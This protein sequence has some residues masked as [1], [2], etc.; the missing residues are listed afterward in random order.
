VSPDLPDIGDLL[1]EAFGPLAGYSEDEEPRAA[2]QAGA[3][4]QDAAVPGVS[5]VRR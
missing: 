2:P 4:G 3:A 5:S 1:D